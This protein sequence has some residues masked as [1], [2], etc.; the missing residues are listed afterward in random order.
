MKTILLETGNFVMFCWAPVSAGLSGN[1]ATDIATEEAVLLEMWHQNKLRPRQQCLCLSSFFCFL[2]LARWMDP[3]TGLQ[4]ATHLLRCRSPPS[5]VSGR[6]KS[7]W[8]AFS[9]A[10]HNLWLGHSLPGDLATSWATYEVP[11]MVLHI[12]VESPCYDFVLMVHCM[13]IYEKNLVIVFS[14]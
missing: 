9:L 14:K 12:L 4:I 1:D 6:S 3:Y 8:R 5:V 2:F 13:I 11:I 10:T 7:Y